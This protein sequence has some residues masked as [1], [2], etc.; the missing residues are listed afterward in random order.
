MKLNGKEHTI[1]VWDTAGQEEFEHIRR[2]A[3]ETLTLSWCAIPQLI[4]Q[5]LK[6]SEKSGS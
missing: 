1:T 3:T 5:V 4:K 2:L 6:I